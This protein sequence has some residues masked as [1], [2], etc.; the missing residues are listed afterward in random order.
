LIFAEYYIRVIVEERNML[1]RFEVENFKGF[2]KKIVFDLSSTSKYEFNQGLVQNGI[3]KNGV[4]FGKNGSGKTNLGIAIFD[5]VTNLTN[6]KTSTYGANEP[7]VNFNSNSNNVSFLYEFVFDEDRVTYSYQKDSL[8]NLINEDLMINNDVLL[9]YDYNE[10]NG[11]S[12]LKGTESL[13][14]DLQN[15]RI[16]F[17]KYVFYNSILSQS[18]YND[19]FAQMMDFVDK[20]LMFS[21]FRSYKLFVHLTF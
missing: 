12:K 19:L 6:N 13:N 4:I 17:V 1:A 15:K 2:E 18:R 7:F 11:Y 16:S 10:K 3:V 9:H 8:Q 20:M 5:I 14:T 21:W